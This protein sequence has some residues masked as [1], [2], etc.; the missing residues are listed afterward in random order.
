ML[1]RRWLRALAAASS[2]WVFMTW[3]WSISRRKASTSVSTYSFIW[4][5][6]TAA[7]ASWV[8]AL[9]QDDEWVQ[10]GDVFPGAGHLVR[11]APAAPPRDAT[12]VQE[13]VPPH[14]RIAALF[15]GQRRQAL[16]QGD[17][18]PAETRQ[19]IA[20]PPEE[21]ERRPIRPPDLSDEPRVERRT[22]L[23]LD[24]AQHQRP[25]PEATVL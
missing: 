16:R 5:S 15:V 6:F 10:Q 12:P 11:T 8:K 9:R 4:T 14:P 25:V 7:R 1:S 21:L 2:A 17:E 18:P 23:C 13:P 19:P 3:R 24:R 20:P 22:S